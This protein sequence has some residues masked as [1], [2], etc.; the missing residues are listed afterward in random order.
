MTSE[1]HLEIL[2]DNFRLSEA[3]DY[4][5]SLVKTKEISVTR[6]K[7]CEELIN[8]YE[9]IICGFLWNEQGLLIL[10]ALKNEDETEKD[11]EE[12]KKRLIE[13]IDLLIKNKR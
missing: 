10:S 9:Q 3:K 7:A 1:N 13:N 6:G 8:T 11:I 12:E 2:L 5:A 4:V